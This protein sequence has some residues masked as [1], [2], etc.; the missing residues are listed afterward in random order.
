MIF[1]RTVSITNFLVASS[2]LS[3]QVFVLYPWH[4]ELDAGFEALKKEHIR[5]LDAAGAA[6]GGQQARG[7]SD[8]LKERL[9]G[10]S[11]RRW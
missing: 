6:V 10:Q 3:F 4:K 8:D 7:P 11:S 5:L 1:A 2:A 9:K